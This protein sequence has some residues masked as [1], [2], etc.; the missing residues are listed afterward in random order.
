MKSAREKTRVI[1]GIRS[2][3]GHRALLVCGILSS[4]GKKAL[5]VTGALL[6]AY[7]AVGPLW[8]P[9]PMTARGARRVP[10]VGGGARRRPAA[11]TSRDH[12][13][14]SSLLRAGEVPLWLVRP[15]N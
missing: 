9:F 1:M 14:R 2:D 15:Y 6:I 13:S 5:R 4:H 7:G 11:W 12:P 10:A 8:L 3:D